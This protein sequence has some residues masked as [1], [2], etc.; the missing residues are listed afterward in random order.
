MDIP[1]VL[2][3]GI[4]PQISVFLSNNSPQQKKE[5]RC[6]VCGH[7]VFKYW[8]DLRIIMAGEEDRGFKKAP[9]EIQ[10]NGSYTANKDGRNFTTTCKSLFYVS[11]SI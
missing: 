4:K 10:C 11:Q 2:N 5:F 3:N 6:P 7:I 1:T 9:L 8:D